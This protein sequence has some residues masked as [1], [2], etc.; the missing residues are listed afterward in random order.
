MS[1]N[2]LVARLDAFEWQWKMRVLYEKGALPIAENIVYK[3]NTDKQE[4]VSYVPDIEMRDPRFAKLVETEDSGPVYY[5]K[6]VERRF[7]GELDKLKKD[8]MNKVQE[9]FT[10]ARKRL[11]EK[12]T[13]IHGKSQA[14]EYKKA[15]QFLEEK[16]DSS[17]S[18]LEK[19]CEQI[20]KNFYALAIK[21]TQVLR[22]EVYM[23]KEL[24]QRGMKVTSGYLDCVNYLSHPPDQTVAAV[25]KGSQK[26]K[27]L[28]FAKSAKIVPAEQI[29]LS[30]RTDYS[31][32]NRLK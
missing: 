6:G 3:P 14:N 21:E 16:R 24:S 7:G 2:P 15:L 26:N 28:T 4:T 32:K 23:A 20:R 1:K 25:K 19:K 22:R 27:P 13:L 17:F 31:D 11:E 8:L 30:S 12:Y 9:G 5:V 10:E 29:D 18:A